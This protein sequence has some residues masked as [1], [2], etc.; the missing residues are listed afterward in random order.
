MN[1]NSNTTL[2]WLASI[3]ISSILEIFLSLIIVIIHLYPFYISLI[4]VSINDFYLALSIHCM[5]CWGYSIYEF[6]KSGI[7]IPKSLLKWHIIVLKFLKE[8]PIKAIFFLIIIISIWHYFQKPKIETNQFDLIQERIDKLTINI[9]AESLWAKD[10]EQDITKKLENINNNTDYVYYSKDIKR[11]STPPDFAQLPTNKDGVEQLSSDF[12]SVLTY[13]SN[14]KLDTSEINNS[15]NK[16][17][18]I[19]NDIFKQLSEINNQT[20]SIC[21]MIDIKTDKN[22]KDIER[23]NNIRHTITKIEKRSKSTQQSLNNIEN[24]IKEINILNNTIIIHPSILAKWEQ[25]I[26]EL[27]GTF[28]FSEE[29]VEYWLERSSFGIKNAKETILKAQQSNQSLIKQIEQLDEQ[30]ISLEKEYNT[31]VKSINNSIKKYESQSNNIFELKQALSSAINNSN[32]LIDFEQK[33]NNIEQLTGEEKKINKLLQDSEIN[34]LNFYSTHLRHLSGGGHS[35]FVRAKNNSLG[36]KYITVILNRKKEIDEL[37]KKVFN[38]SQETKILLNS[39]TNKKLELTRNVGKLKS[40]LKNLQIRN[41]G[42]I[43]QSEA[44][45][46]RSNLQLIMIFVALIFILVMLVW[47]QYRK[48]SLNK[49]K[50]IKTNKVS[51]L[52]PFIV[53]S[54][55]PIKVRLHAINILYNEVYSPTQQEI[56]QIKDKVRILEVSSENSDKK[57][58]A[59]LRMVADAMELRSSEGR[60][61]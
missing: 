37:Q 56:T 42:I 13:L 4:N 7:A 2:F 20:V 57:V 51:G 31:H 1:N 32:I 21:K 33:L 17:L 29:N 60:G 19:L 28:D 9:D 41:N 44:T 46:F 38:I 5:C 26:E 58:A 18:G 25:T 61:L 27:K 50:N 30:L 49:I 39:I 3:I 22:D 35:L 34:F 16:K 54:N 12:K 47:Q 23:C 48:R 45:I 8:N 14:Q 36:N 40:S 24:T 59:K 6:I 52:I 43:K 55:D 10:K 15:L 11:F 53:N